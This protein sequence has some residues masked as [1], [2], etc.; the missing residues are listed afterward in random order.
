MKKLLL[1]ICL[2]LFLLPGAHAREMK[3][4]FSERYNLLVSKL[5]Y[6]GVGIE[7]LLDK[8]E[9]NFPDDPDVYFHRFMYY[10]DKSSS[11]VVEKKNKQQYMG[12][13]PMLSL[14]D[15]L[16][17]KVNYFVVVSYDE[18][19]FAKAMSNI[20]KAIALNPLALN[21]RLAK[22]DAWKANENERPDET[23]KLLNELIDYH[24]KSSPEWVYDENNATDSD[25]F[26]QIVQEYCAS[27]FKTASDTSLAAFKSVSEKMLSYNSK[28]VYASDNMGS[29]YLLHENNS[30]KALKYYN[31]SLKIKKDDV[32]AI[33][34]SVT[35][36]RKLKK[37]KKEIFCLLELLKYTKDEAEQT[38]IKNRLK[39]LNYEI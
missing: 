37:P 10:F 16:G 5:G 28:N 17:N 24:Y 36:Y 3:E 11:T 20:D 26:E 38:A 27:F 14:K 34:N 30:K 39:A 8:W 12:N 1:G 4:E 21:L 35:A 22:I 23:V 19:L 31:K 18:H 25:I 32:T 9:K 29:F 13:A 2:L 7:T 33:K 6:S 15:S